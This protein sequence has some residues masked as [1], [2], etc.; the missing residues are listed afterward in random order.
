MESLDPNRCDKTPGAE[1]DLKQ[2]GRQ[3]REDSV[4]MWRPDPSRCARIVKFEEAARS[5]EKLKGPPAE[6]EL[7][8]SALQQAQRMQ[9]EAA[10]SGA[11]TQKVSAREE[12]AKVDQAVGREAMSSS[13]KRR[14]RDKIRKGYLKQGQQAQQH[15]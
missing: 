8:K 7:I 10:Q 1:P 13:K 11:A 2:K 6:K 15:Q 5:L 4:Q 3:E 9:E 14:I 12:I